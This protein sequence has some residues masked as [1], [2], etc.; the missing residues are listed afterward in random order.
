MAM[1]PITTE[2]LPAYEKAKIRL[3]SE[4]QRDLP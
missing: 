3:A 2:R 4:I 1:R